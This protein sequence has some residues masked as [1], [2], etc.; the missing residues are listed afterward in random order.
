MTV[1]E[2]KAMLG[3][4]KPEEVRKLPKLHYFPSKPETGAIPDSFESAEQWPGCVHPIRNQEQCGSC[5]AFGAS[6]ALS[7]R[8]CVASNGSVNVVLSP[9]FLVSCDA[10]NYGCDGGM[11]DTVWE[12]MKN[13]GVVSD[14]CLPYTAGS[15]TAGACAKTC[16]DGT[17]F[18]F[19]KVSDYYHVSTWLFW[20]KVEKIQT[21]IM[22][23]GP[24]EAAFTVYQ[25][26]MSY[27]SGVYHHVSG[28]QLG[29]HAIKIVGWGVASDGTPY[30][31]IANSWSTTWGQNG[32]FWIKRGSNEC[33]IEDEVYAGT[34]AL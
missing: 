13:T 24:V 2:A 21:E 7:D 29:G 25:D 8:F 3:H 20:N 9:Q 15:G 31:N 6:E 32:F 12:F 5:W 34:P 19:Y 11:L 23:K 4:V 18:K 16:A 22:T 27:S 17:P 33:G 28:N 1:D 30:W 26:F 10:S 14:Q